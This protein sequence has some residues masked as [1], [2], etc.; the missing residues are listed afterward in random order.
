[1]QGFILHDLKNRIKTQSSAQGKFIKLLIVCFISFS[2]LHAQDLKSK[3]TYFKNLA[4]AYQNTNPDSSSAY[5]DS[6]LMTA[7]SMEEQ[8]YLGIAFQMKGR[9][10]FMRSDADSALHY[11]K[12][13]CQIFQ[14]YPD[15]TAHYTSQYNLGNIYLYMEEHM[16]A[17]VQ[18]KK[19]LRIIDENFNAYTTDGDAKINLNRAYCY[20]SIGLVYDYMGDYFAKLE[21]MQ[22]G[23]KIAQNIQGRESEILQAVTLG[24]IGF[25]YN[26]LG[27][28]VS[29]ES[30]AIA[31]MELKKKLGIDASS[32][33]NYQVLAKAAFGRKKY[34]LSLKYLQIADKYFK[35]LKNNSELN[36]N[37][38]L[39]ARC[40]FAQN[41]YDLA[42]EI[43]HNIERQFDEP[44]FKRERIELYELISEIYSSRKDYVMS[45]SYLTIALKLQKELSNK[46]NKDATDQFL[47]FF[48]EEENRIDDK[49]D[50]FKNIQDKEKLQVEVK[51]RKEKELWIYSLFIVSIVC[52]VLIIIVIARGNRR[53]KK[54]NQELNYSMDEKEI[55]FREVHHRVKNNF[56]I[57]S[58]LLNLQQGIEEDTRSKKVLTDA[59]GRIQ[60]MSLV[61]ELLYRK[62]EVK[63]I[64]FKTYTQELVSSIIRSYT[65]DKLAI[66]CEIKCENESFDLELAVP[67]GLIL[68]EAI[69]NA[70]KYAFKGKNSG[71][72]TVQLKPLDA[73]NYSLVIKD[74]GVGIP[75]EFINGSKETLGIELI[76]ILSEQLG[77]S[78]TFLNSNGTEVQVVFS[79]D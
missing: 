78:A 75:E 50:N 42:L 16:Q 14:F 31:G 54:I 24:N 34:S 76:N 40:F 13:A 33:Y 79:N 74:N 44:G 58:S 27:D 19:V 73:K 15:S 29:A 21:N 35:Q 32:G 53:N 59:Q 51:T 9:D 64:D 61:H 69:T 10:F 39:R 47:A 18:F 65:D 62:N 12:S 55:L 70:V 56:Q 28:F 43:L 66:S 11:E 63:R 60:S 38:L 2:Q 8:Y 45:T 3:F 4:L 17:L 46:D 48:E 67:L 72:I 20:V 23:L 41:K 77:G 7:R 37:E 1:L 49:L 68:N 5:T 26:E 57:I 22:K 36:K 30:Y 6:C 52:L 25:A 71:A